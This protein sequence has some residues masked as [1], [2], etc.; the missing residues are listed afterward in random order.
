MLQIF[1]VSSTPSLKNPFWTRYFRCELIFFL[2]RLSQFQYLASGIHNQPKFLSFVDT[3][4]R[5]RQ[6]LTPAASAH[7]LN[8]D[9]FLKNAFSN[10]LHLTMRVGKNNKKVFLVFC[11]VWVAWSTIFFPRSWALF[12]RV[13]WIQPSADTLFSSK[14]IA[15]ECF[16]F[17]VCSNRPEVISSEPQSLFHAF[18]QH[19]NHRTCHFSARISVSRL[20]TILM[21]Q[22]FCRA[23]AHVCRHFF[24]SRT[25]AFV[26]ENLFPFHFLYF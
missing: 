10:I 14:L 13:F 25:N 26:P 1:F 20:L 11:R 7:Y 6:L 12:S 22:L 24:F 9:V 16:V 5:P 18:L 8:C 17:L 2:Y 4:K 21:C 19:Q 23:F 15:Y 3:R